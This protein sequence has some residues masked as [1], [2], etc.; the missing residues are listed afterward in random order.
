MR[1]RPSRPGVR[2]ARGAA[3]AALAV[4]CAA[5]AAG[6]EKSREP[7]PLE[8][9]A[10]IRSHNGRSSFDL[11]PDGEWVAHTAELDQTVAKDTDCFSPTGKPFAEGDARMQARLT[12]TTSDKV[13][14]LGGTKGS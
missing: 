8:V 1:S 7:L 13:V 5:P 3:A 6:G 9:A 12:S 2:L 11:S 10:S 14:P 4:L